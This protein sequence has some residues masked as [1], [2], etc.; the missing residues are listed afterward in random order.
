MKYRRIILI[1][2]SFAKDLNSKQEQMA[3][4]T[5]S[6]YFLKNRNN[7]FWKQSDSRKNYFFTDTHLIF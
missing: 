7:N 4:V 1:E 2:Q 3:K 6:I 5:N